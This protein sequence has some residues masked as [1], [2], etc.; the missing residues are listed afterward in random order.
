MNIE[1][2]N[3]NRALL[4]IDSPDE[5]FALADGARNVYPELTVGELD[6]YMIMAG[7]ALRFTDIAQSE[8]FPRLMRVKDKQ[9]ERIAEGLTGLFAGT[10]DEFSIYKATGRRVSATVDVYAAEN[11]TSYESSFLVLSGYR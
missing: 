6:G 9:V 7:L 3:K 8:R 10:E 1:K 5:G 11:I 2:L 4:R